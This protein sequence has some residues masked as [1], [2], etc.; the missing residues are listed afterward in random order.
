MAPA[1]LS[2]RFQSFTQLPTMKPGPSGAG[3]RPSGWACARPRPLWVSPM[4]SPVRLGVSPAA[5]QPPQAFSIRGLRLYF[6]TLEPWVARSALFPAV[7]PVYLCGNV[8]PRGATRCSACPILR[9]SESGPL[10]LSVR[11]CGAA[12]SALVR[13]PAPFVPHSASLGPAMATRVL[14]APTARLQPSYQSG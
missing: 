6:P 12:C 3:S 14:F 2:T 9:H 10:G 13:L 11:E 8:G 5:A 1:P 7:C 4:T